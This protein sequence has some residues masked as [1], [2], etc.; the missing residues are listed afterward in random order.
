[1]HH[2][3]RTVAIV[4]TTA[5]SVVARCSALASQ[6]IVGIYLSE[7]EVGTY[8]L[9]IGIVGVTGLW[10][11]GGS[12]LV[13]PSIKPEEYDR[14]AGAMFWWATAFMGFSA[15]LTV[16]AA[17]L[18]PSLP[19]TMAAYRTGGLPVALL[20]MAVRLLLMPVAVVGRMRVA[21]EHRFV[22]LARVDTLNAIVRLA[23]TWWVAAAGGGVLAL[24]IPYAAQTAVDAIAAGLLG[25]LRSADFRWPRMPLRDIARI[26]AWPI[27]AAMMMSMRADVSFLVIGLLIP[28]AALGA[29]YFAFQLANQPSMLLAG[30]LQNVLAPILAR[31]RG[32]ADA[33]RDGIERVFNAS[34][35]FVPVVTLATASL[36]PPAE[37]LVWGGKWAAV[38]TGM[39]FLCIGATYATVTGL[40]VGPL[41]G[42]Q[43]FKAVTGFEAFKIVG[44]IGGAL[45]GAGVIAVAATG[46]RPASTITLMCAAV[47]MTIAVTSVVQL[48]WIMN[49]Y[50]VAKS[51]TWR[52]MAYGPALA[53]LT[54]LASDSIGD[55]IMDSFGLPGGRLG[56]AIELAVIGTVYTGLTMLAIRFT[57]ESTLRETVKILPGPAARVLTRIFGLG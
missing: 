16:G 2:R 28:A 53:M 46:D 39:Y 8:A 47:G 41:L 24:A 19:D 27:A 25:G 32:N 1:M 12:T 52:A 33:E 15:L 48:A 23:I 14:W 56:A 57:A 9:A 29:F 22:P 55:S 11:S 34:M 40:M 17:G 5:A 50:R 30:S 45:V 51:A 35:L 13:L 18:I 31:A 54:A 37:R 7:E 6:A 26:M 3:S 21:V 10:R 43:R 49:R 4:A 44:T 42:L 20:V 38:S 36:F